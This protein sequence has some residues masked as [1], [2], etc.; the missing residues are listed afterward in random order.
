MPFVVTE[1]KSLLQLVSDAHHAYIHMILWY[2]VGV[3]TIVRGA[4]VIRTKYCK[5]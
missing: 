4:I 2:E 3:Y 5:R 1:Y